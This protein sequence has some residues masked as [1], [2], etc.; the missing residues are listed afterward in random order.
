MLRSPSTAVVTVTA[1]VSTPSARRAE[2]PSIAGKISHLPHL[3]TSEYSE[4]MPPSPLLSAFMAMITY[5]I[6]VSR[7][8]D[9]ITSESEPMMNSGLTSMMPPLPRTMDFMT[10]IGEVPMSP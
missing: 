3:R 1:G 7:V 10:Y 4:K 5:L 9:Q 2:P 8:I 6:V